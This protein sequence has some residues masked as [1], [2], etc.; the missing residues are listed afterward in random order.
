[1]ARN[2]FVTVIVLI[3]GMC[4]WIGCMDGIVVEL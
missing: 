4:V 3:D 1:M 2:E